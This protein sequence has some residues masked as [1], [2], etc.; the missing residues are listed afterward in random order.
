MKRLAIRPKS[1]CQSSP[2]VDIFHLTIKSECLSRM[3]FFG[4]K[5]LRLAVASYLVH[6]HKQRNHQS[7]DNSII[8]PGDEVGQTEGEVVCS[9]A[10]GGM[11]RY[12]HR[13]AA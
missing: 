13:I 4:E 10:L 2:A 6:Y 7:L 9:Q 5:S 11:L 3:I 1:H 12:Y 8:T